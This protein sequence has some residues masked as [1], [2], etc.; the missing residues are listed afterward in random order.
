VTTLARIILIASLLAAAPA[1]SEQDARSPAAMMDALMWGKEPVGGPFAL[2]DQ[3]GRMRTDE[4]FRGKLLLLYFGYT[5]C[6]DV[7]PADVLSITLALQGLGDRAASV[8]PIFVTLDPERDTA[9]HLADYLESFD[10]RWIGL[11][12]DK[13]AIGKLALDYK[14]WFAKAENARGDDYSIDHTS[15]IFLVGRDGKYIGFLPPGTEPERIM[16]AVQGHL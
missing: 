8:Q 3:H 15:V 10:P 7:C 1:S 13:A 5:R 9:E 2:H 6:P 12:G 4:E 11:T 14:I 16:E